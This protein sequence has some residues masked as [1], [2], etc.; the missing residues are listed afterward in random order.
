MGCWMTR[1]KTL[2][3][4]LLMGLCVQVRQP[5]QKI[6]IMSNQMKFSRDQEHQP[7][8]EDEPEWLREGFE[9]FEDEDTFGVN[10]KTKPVLIGNENPEQTDGQVDPEPEDQQV[11]HKEELDGQVNTED[12]NY[13]EAG[14]EEGDDEELLEKH[15]SDAETKEYLEFNLEVEF[16]KQNFDLKVG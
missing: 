11:N 8:D 12:D 16:K 15:G 7:K 6:L 5:M 3:M 4:D 2:I 13:E 1:V 9:T 14:Y 10:S